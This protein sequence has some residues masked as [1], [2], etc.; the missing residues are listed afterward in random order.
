[1]G[2]HQHEAALEAAQQATSYP[3]SGFFP[4]LLTAAAAGQLGRHDVAAR[5]V[6]QVLEIEPEFTCRR[7]SEQFPVSD[8]FTE[9]FIEGAAESRPPRIVRRGD[10]R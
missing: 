4:K 9:Q 7:Q 10:G 8:D 3:S 2:M 5:A 6:S 1:M